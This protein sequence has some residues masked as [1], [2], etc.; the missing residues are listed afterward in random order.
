MLLDP[1]S[2]A[3]RRVPLED[4]QL[5]I[6]QP[7]NFLCHFCNRRFKREV[8]FLKHDC[9]KKRRQQEIRTPIG[10]AAYSYYREWM[11][12]RRFKEQSAAAFI[13]SNFYNA[14]INFAKMVQATNIGKPERYIQLMVECDIP[15]V[16]WCRDNAYAIYLDWVDTLSDPMDT[17]QNSIEYLIEMGKKLGVD[18]PNIIDALGSQQV[19]SLIRQRRLSPWVVFNS[20]KFGDMLRALSQ[21][22]LKAFNL[23]INSSYWAKKFQGNAEL[24]QQIK[25][26][27]AEMGL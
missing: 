14:F 9:K 6:S 7:G 11:R 18:L 13:D 24:V 1:V 5:K 2:I 8:L 26:I 4:A 3:E 12:I 22:E 25:N 17:V 20:K 27:I 16:L 21:D 23:V 15:P 19:L 10:Q